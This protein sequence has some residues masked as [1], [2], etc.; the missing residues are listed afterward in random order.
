MKIISIRL[1]PIHF[2]IQ[3][4]LAKELEGSKLDV[5]RI[6]KVAYNAHNI[7]YISLIHLQIQ[8]NLAKEL[9]GSKL[10]VQRIKK[11]AYNAKRK[12]LDEKER[13]RKIAAQKAKEAAKK[14]RIIL[15][16][17]VI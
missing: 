9:E 2:Q 4:N 14:V 5:Q 15:V 17:W 10:D 11:V 16:K 6:K 12:I 1:Y 8:P 3:P 7:Y 13:Q